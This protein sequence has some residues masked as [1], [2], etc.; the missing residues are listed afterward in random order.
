MWLGGVELMVGVTNSCTC[1]TYAYI[2]RHGSSAK[3][4]PILDVMRQLPFHP[5]SS[6]NI[7]NKVISNQ[8]DRSGSTNAYDYSR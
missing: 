6:I 2:L 3:M 5:A 4:G 1:V 7:Y 8:H